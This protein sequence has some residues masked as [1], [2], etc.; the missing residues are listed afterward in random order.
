MKVSKIIHQAF[1]DVDEQGSEAAAATALSIELTGVAR[2]PLKPIVFRADKPFLF[3]L[4]DGRTGAI[5]FIGRHVA[6]AP[7]G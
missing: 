3:L 2:K 7:P 5:L 6:P 4:H 1:L